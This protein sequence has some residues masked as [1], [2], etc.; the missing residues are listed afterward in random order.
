MRK[1]REEAAKTRGR[2]VLTAAKM[3][4]EKGLSGVGMRDIMAAARLTQGAFYR[5]FASKEQLIAEANSTA[6]ERLHE[7]F[8]SETRGLSPAETMERIVALYLGQSRGMK[9]PY[10][11]PLAMLGTELSHGNPQ[12]RAVAINGYQRLVQLLADQLGHMSRREALATADG[13][14]ST[15]VGAVT[16]AQIA[17]DTATA[18][19]ILNNARALINERLS[20]A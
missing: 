15:L 11:C 20:P 16:L 1:S 10:L 17:P 18:N 12:V 3:F 14:F 6:F 7:M 13:I 19:A 4:L 9:Q 8:V 5:H 2:I